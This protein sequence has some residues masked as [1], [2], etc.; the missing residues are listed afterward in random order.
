MGI[1]K[2]NDI[3]GRVPDELHPERMIRLGSIIAEL[4][5]AE[6]KTI[7]LG[8][9]PRFETD[10]LKAGL[11]AG[12]TSMGKNIADMG[13]TTTPST[14]FAA[15]HNKD[16]DASIMITASHNPLGTS[17]LK[18]SNHKGEAF[19]YEN[20]FS[21]VEKLEKQEKASTRGITQGRIDPEK[22]ARIKAQYIEFLAHMIQSA[23]TELNKSFAIEYGNGSATIFERVLTI[24]GANHV[25]LHSIP[26]GRFPRL[27]PDPA[28]DSCYVDLRRVV[29]ALDLDYGL[30]FD[31]D[32]DRFGATDE[33]G[34]RISPDDM[35]MILATHVLKEYPGSTIIIDVKTSLATKQYL[36]DMG[37]RVKYTRVGHSWVH[38]T[39]LR[40][41]AIFA[42]ELSGHYYFSEK[43]YGFDDALYSATQFISFVEQLDSSV[44]E[45]IQK[46]P[47]FHSTPEIR[48]HMPK[49]K[50]VM[51]MEKA[52]DIAEALGGRIIDI[53]GVRAEFDD[54]W[55]LV[56][57]SGTESALS[58]RVEG[59]SPERKEELLAAVKKLLSEN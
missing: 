49:D 41:N 38:E 33:K 44:S 52:V 23:V 15:A 39:L 58:Y 20:F 9:D 46:L 35:T 34:R 28:T 7:A 8:G 17:G 30:A 2:K 27:L 32:G 59:K 3:R 19:H 13:V 45:F 12:L 37:A 29:P 21:E 53:D 5:P 48:Q 10:M 54:G 50:I 18:V 40:E 11:I 31:A 26:N 25:G 55:F 24:I 57:S 42:A 4:L 16:I 47:H 56:R 22:G 14:Y 51:I 36:E 1:Y 43:Y 6:T